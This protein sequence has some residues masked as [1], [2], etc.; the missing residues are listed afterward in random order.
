[1]TTNAKIHSYAELKKLIHS[2]LRKEHPEWIGPD[3]ESEMCN[4]YEDRFAKLLGHE[5]VLALS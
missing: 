4:S 5:V 3:G 2:A 1:M